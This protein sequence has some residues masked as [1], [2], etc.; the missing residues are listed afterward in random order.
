[1]VSVAPCSPQPVAPASVINSDPGTSSFS[2]GFLPGSGATS[3]SIDYGISTYY[4]TTISAI[5]P[6]LISGLAAGTTYHYRVNSINSCGTNLGTD[7]T[8]ITA[9]SPYLVNEGFEGGTEPTGWT[10]DTACQYNYATAPA[11]L[12]GSYSMYCTTAGSDAVKSFTA[13]D[14]I[15]TTA[16]INIPTA[17]VSTELFM[18]QYGLAQVSR[19][20]NGKLML[21]LYPGPVTYEGTAG[22]I[23]AATN[24][25]IKIQYVKGTGANGIVNVSTSTTGYTWNSKISVTDG[26]NTAQMSNIG[27]FNLASGYPIIVD[28]VKVSTADIVDAR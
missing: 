28:S 25:Y 27:F 8:A 21:Q 1:M 23:P 3:Y 14:T 4:G 5:S 2:V 22:D 17:N 6:Q 24:L 19:E 26:P 13:S 9:A 15:Y 11:P 10:H 7:Y 20:S 18:G 16:R 12:S